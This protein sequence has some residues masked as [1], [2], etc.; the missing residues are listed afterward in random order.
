MLCTGCDVFRKIAGRPTAAELVS[1]QESIR[2]AK[3]AKHAAMM[4]SLAKVEKYMADSLAAL[5]SLNTV[6]GTPVLNS[7][8]IGGLPEESLEYRY[9]IVVGSFINRDNAGKLAENVRSHGYE[10][11]LISFRNGYTAV[12]VCPSDSIVDTY[13]SFKEIRNKEFCPDGVWILAK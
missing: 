5:D 7:E 2:L 4:D 3:E 6:S 10:P 1:K 13:A 12:A 9:Y 8:A 11:Q